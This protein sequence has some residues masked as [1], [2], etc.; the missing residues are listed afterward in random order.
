MSRSCTIAGQAQPIQQQQRITP[1]AVLTV[2]VGQPAA[3]LICVQELVPQ[4]P[5][6]APKEHCG[7][8]AVNRE[9]TVAE[10]LAAPI[11][12]Q[13]KELAGRR[14]RRRRRRLRSSWGRA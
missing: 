9:D 14:G 7:Q 13:E 12:Q 5:E 11:R 1:Q 10:A 4:R 8:Q 3:D 2:V 6:A